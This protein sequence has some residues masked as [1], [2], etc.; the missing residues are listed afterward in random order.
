MVEGTIDVEG[1]GVGDADVLSVGVAVVGIGVWIPVGTFVTTGAGE[2]TSL[3]G[4]TVPIVDGPETDPGVDVA[5]VTF[6][7]CA[8][9]T[10]G[11]PWN[12]RRKINAR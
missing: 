5:L 8:C 4:A 10:K 6:C 9:T 7:I 1:N 11:V 3:F 2:G 12:A